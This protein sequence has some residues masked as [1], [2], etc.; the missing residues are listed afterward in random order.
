MTEHTGVRGRDRRGTQSINYTSGTGFTGE[1]PADLY[2][3]HP[4]INIFI[5]CLRA[6]LRPCR[7]GMS[8]ETHILCA[9]GRGD[10][11]LRIRDFPRR[12]PVEYA[13]S[14][15]SSHAAPVPTSAQHEARHRSRSSA[16]VLT[17]LHYA[18]HVEIATA[19][20]KSSNR[21]RCKEI[22]HDYRTW[23]SERRD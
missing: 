13:S 17:D 10:N 12:P 8:N 4:A 18:A 11:S 7:H 6:F 19:S 9:F 22:S 2:N 14:Q 23:Q 5:A 3:W 16:R 15:A 1:T 21:S 20:S